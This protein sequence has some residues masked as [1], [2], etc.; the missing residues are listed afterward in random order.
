MRTKILSI[1]A[2]FCCLAL[3]AWGQSPKEVLILPIEMPG[4][5][6]PLESA[7]LTK[8]FEQKLAKV[9]PRADLQVSTAADLT[10][11]QYKAGAEKPPT[12][13][14][15]EKMCRAYQANYVCWTSVSFRPDF[16]SSTGSLALGGA[17]R[18]W[19][20]SQDKHNVV[21]DQPVSLVRAG[22]VPNV[23]DEKA[24]RA[25]AAELAQGCVEDLAVQIAS[26]A[27]NRQQQPQT[28]VSS[29]Q[30]PK[31]FD[32]TQSANY[33][34]MVN[35]AQ[36]Y[37]RAEKNQ[38]LIN[39]TSSLSDMQ[40]L[41]TQLTQPERQAINQ[42]YPGINELMQPAPVYGGGYWPYRYR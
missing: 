23:K 19:V 13:E 27:R 38:S 12:I 32:A 30:P 2:T 41:W 5:Y 33:K 17:A 14:D 26:I 3:G 18:L 39:I 31:D 25:V 22:H 36:L 34:A 28:G 11:Y 8:V 1:L 40:M 20:Y 6:N 29:W 42:N 10:A 21:V 15:A 24:S 9:A 16:N 4:Y 37:Q 35:A 7:E